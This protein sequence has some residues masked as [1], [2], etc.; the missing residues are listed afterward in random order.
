MRKSTKINQSWFKE[1]SFE[2]DF[3]NFEKQKSEIISHDELIDF[4]KSQSSK[5]YDHLIDDNMDLG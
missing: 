1:E 4:V 2:E 5:S 3:K